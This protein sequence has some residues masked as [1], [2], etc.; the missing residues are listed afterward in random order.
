MAHRPSVRGSSLL[1]VALLAAC[2]G[3]SKTAWS[4]GEPLTLDVAASFPAGTVVRDAYSGATATVDG[5]GKVTLPTSG[6]AGLLLLEKDGAAASPFDWQNATVYYAITDRFS[7][8]DTSNDGSYGRKKDG[9]EEVGTWHGGDWKGLTA[10]LPYL[11][12]LGVTAVWISPI[13][14][15]VHGWVAGGAGAYQHYGYHGYWALDFTRLDANFGDEAALKAMVD[16]A[17]AAG[18]R[19]LVDVIIN[20]PGYATGDDLLAYLPGVFKPGGAAAFAA[21]TPSAPRGYDAWNDLVNYSSPSWTDWWNPT[22]VRAGLGPTFTTCGTASG[23]ACTDTTR[24]VSSLPDFITEGAA[25]A[26]RP[27]FFAAKPDTG[28]TGPLTNGDGSGYTV[29][30]YLVKWHADWVRRFGIDGFRC[31][32]AK[33]VELESWR[34]LKTAATAALAEWK[35]A[36]P[37]ALAEDKPFWMT[38][39]VFT[40]GPTKDVYYTQGGFDS[41]INFD[42][43]PALGSLLLQQGSLV[44]GAKDLEALYAPTAALVSADAAFDPLTYLSSH[45]TYLFF[46]GMKKDPAKMRQAGTALLLMPGAV[47]VFYGDESGRIMGPTGGDAVQ[48]TRSDMNW[49]AVDATIHDHWQKVATF[50]KR[51]AAVGAGAHLQLA[52]PGGTYAFSRKRGDDAVVVALLPTN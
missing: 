22:W 39:E 51:H 3:S 47:Q 13:V 16:A 23:P 1:L 49:D 20:H 36:H 32:T 5:A 31:D 4:P 14:E 50:R 27:I 46:E 45:D 42:F 35:A 11:Q 21:F 43:Q 17:H 38:G 25:A 48:G 24:Q 29:R 2:G 12:A 10:K 44:A 7:N 19:V 8:G 28:F 6:G 37:G 52:S 26:G 33:N 34:A 30:Q 41:L 40:H 18:I 15:Q 9:K